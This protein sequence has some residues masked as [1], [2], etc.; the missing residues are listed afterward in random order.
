MWEFI[1]LHWKDG[2]EIL[3]LAVLLYQGYRFLK[4]TRGARILTGLLTLMLGLTLISQLLELDVMNW[5]LSHFSVFLAVG[6]V[7]IF[8]PE[9]RRVLAEL[10]SHRFF[11][12]N[13]AEAANVDLLLE[14]MVEL[15]HKRHGALFALQR[16]IDLKQFAESGVMMDAKLS[17]EL[18]RTVF[19][20]KTALH[21]GGMIV[22]QG[23][24]VAAGCVF[25]VSQKEMSDRSIGLRHR[26]GLG[27]SEESDAVA[28]IVSEETGALSMCYRG[29]LE[30]DLE[31]NKLKSRLQQI[32][33][34]GDDEDADSEEGAK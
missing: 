25:P 28:L 22:E 33:M 20:P 24:I 16:G 18:I 2:I 7:V 23:R 29:K 30:H 8:Q 32:L 12:L 15:S 34:F 26:A 21:D 13:S 4:A 19:F 14:T 11:S 5:L 6:L 1:T 10:G 31:L 9:L 3:I 17:S 27:V